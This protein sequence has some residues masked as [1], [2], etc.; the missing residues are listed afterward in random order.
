M[1][2]L[3]RRAVRHSPDLRPLVEIRLLGQLSCLFL[4]YEILAGLVWLYGPLR[5][6]I[7]IRSIQGLAGA[8][9][10]LGS[11]IAVSAAAVTTSSVTHKEYGV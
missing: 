4:I 11:R 8:L 1:F 10:D 9:S 7:Y 5:A 3:H 2:D 6:H